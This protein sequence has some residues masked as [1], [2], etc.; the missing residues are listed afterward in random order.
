MSCLLHSNASGFWRAKV[1]RYACL[2]T[3]MK[4]LVYAHLLSGHVCMHVRTTTHKYGIN[5]SAE[6]VN[7]RRECL[8]ICRPSVF[9]HISPSISS[10]E[11]PARLLHA[12]KHTGV[13]QP[14]NILKKKVSRRTVIDKLVVM[15]VPFHGPWS[16]CFMWQYKLL[17]VYF[18]NS[19]FK[20][21]NSFPFR[22]CSIWGCNIRQP[23]TMSCP[24]A[25]GG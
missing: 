3:H 20:L 14:I 8:L 21:F 11:R 12:D 4:T 22:T 9:Q 17:Q 5:V 13:I 10:P 18:L 23:R 7:T 19:L 16:Y 2:N 25:E 1:N 15:D 24:V 6:H